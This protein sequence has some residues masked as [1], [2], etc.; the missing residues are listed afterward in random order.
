M[1]LALV[2]LPVSGYVYMVTVLGSSVGLNVRFTA[3]IAM[4]NFLNVASVNGILIRDG[5]ALELLNGV[6]TLVFDKT[7]TLTMDQPEI[8]E[9]HTCADLDSDAVLMYA[10]A[11]E[12]RQTH[13]IA[14]AIQAEAKK[15]G[16][17]LP[18]IDQARYEIGYGV[19]VALDDHLIRV[20]SERFMALEDIEQPASMRALGQLGDE[21]GHS[22]V[23]VAVDDRLVGAI[24]L[25]AALRPEVRSVVHEMRRR[26]LDIRMISGD[27]ERPTSEMAQA[28]GIRHYFA[29]TLPQD[30]A[31]V[32]EQL[33]S[34][35]RSVC[36]VG[37]GIND[38][39]ALKKANVSISLRGASTAATD[40]AQIV[41]MSGGLHHLPIVF[42]LAGHYD[43]NMRTGSAVAMAQGVIVIGGALLGVV[44]IVL[45]RVIWLAGLAAGLVIAEFPLLRH[46]GIADSYPQIS[47][48]L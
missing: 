10:A 9:I 41:L 45:G 46:G 12:D 35:G 3:P 20:G 22:L 39:V 33:Q 23:M 27:Q 8:A 7:G 18:E 13:P 32:I 48:P 40:T 2:A 34:E 6:D 19:T 26:N 47:P 28:L 30:K 43:V 29:N 44:G 16:L 14:L 36:F 17:T 25:E 5:R 15:R 37:D 31:R 21:K 4:L 1:L 11:A 42:D 38:S 24:E